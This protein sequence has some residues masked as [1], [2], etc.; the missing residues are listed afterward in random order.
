MFGKDSM[1]DLFHL[2]WFVLG[3][4]WWWNSLLAAWERRRNYRDWMVGDSDRLFHLPMFN[5]K[6]IFMYTVTSG[7][8]VKF[9]GE[10][11][12]FHVSPTTLHLHQTPGRFGSLPAKILPYNTWTILKRCLILIFEQSNHNAVLSLCTL[13]SAN[14]SSLFFLSLTLR[15][16]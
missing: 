9:L 7:E 8:L 16:Y 15:S 6:I 2:L 14:D 5:L 3:R 12:R 10:R 11:K 1:M 4:D 13:N